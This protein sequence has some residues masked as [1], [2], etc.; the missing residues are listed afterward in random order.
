MSQTDSAWRA[1]WAV[2]AV[3]I[4]LCVAVVVSSG[5]GQTIAFAAWAAALGVDLLLLLR[6]V[7]R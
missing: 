4:T 2:Y 7:R 3:V 6:A 1:F 5:K